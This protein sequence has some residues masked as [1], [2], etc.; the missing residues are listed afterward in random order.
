MR[1]TGGVKKPPPKTPPKKW[2]NFSR[3]NFVKLR[4]R[5][6][7]SEF[8]SVLPYVQ[9]KNPRPGGEVCTTPHPPKIVIFG[10]PRGGTPPSPEI[11]NFAISR[12]RAHIL[13]TRRCTNLCTTRPPLVVVTWTRYLRFLVRRGRSLLIRRRDHVPGST[14]SLSKKIKQLK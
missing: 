14:G 2:H 1:Q 7:L 5:G 4:H 9:N 11:A 13:C 10:P 6:F 3:T 12:T 8:R